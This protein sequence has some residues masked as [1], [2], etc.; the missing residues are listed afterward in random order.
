V[1][2]AY[3]SWPWRLG[4]FAC[5]VALLLLW[6]LVA[7][8]SWVSPVFLPSP[9]DAIHTLLDGMTQGELRM[10][11]LLTV[12]RMAYG[13]ALSSI[14]GVVLGALIGSSAA[15]RT[16]VL[17]TLELLRPLPASS[18][19][20]VGIALFGLTNGMVIGAVVF[21]AIWPVLLATVHGFSSVDPR[22]REVARLLRIGRMAFVWKFGLP[23]AVPDILAGM[24][25]SLTASLIVTI[26]GE[27]L[28]TQEGL[29]TTILLAARSFRA[30]DLYAGVLMLGAIGFASSW[31]LARV[32]GLLLA[33]TRQ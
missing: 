30:A 13:W 12:E 33:A 9:I 25:L 29:G 3:S 11:T 5:V 17:P 27:M 19:V 10:R 7:E 4:S 2:S 15:A 26:V 6:G 14:A 1:K 20:P 16:W 23:N 31:L 18:L 24:R 28:S 22:L 21:G 8:R 32:E